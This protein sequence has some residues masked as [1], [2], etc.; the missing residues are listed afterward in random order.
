[1]KIIFILL[2]ISI[3][4]WIIPT[5]IKTLKFK[6]AYNEY[7]RRC[8]II[9]L[10]LKRDVSG[11]K[12]YHKEMV[13]YLDILY[14]NISSP[15]NYDSHDYIKQSE[16]LFNTFKHIIPEFRQEDRDKKLKKIL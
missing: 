1:M 3:I 11:K 8:D 9:V 6:K 12:L 10:F 14:K 7:N 16:E 15:S 13:K 2:L 4:F 5:I